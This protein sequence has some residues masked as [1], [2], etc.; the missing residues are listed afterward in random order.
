VKNFTY[1]EAI[2]KMPT[3][4]SAEELR[5][6]LLRAGNRFAGRLR[7]TFVVLDDDVKV[8]RDRRDR[9]GPSSAAPEAV[10]ER[11]DEVEEVEEDDDDERVIIQVQSSSGVKRNKRGPASRVANQAKKTS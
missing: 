4:F 9:A 6:V 11:V 3:N 10:S 2:K 7:S 1:I 8:S 5:P